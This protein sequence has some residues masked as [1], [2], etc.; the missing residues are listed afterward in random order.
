MT[1]TPRAYPIRAAARLTGVSIDTLRAWERRYQAVVPERGE[2]GRI[3]RDAHIARLRNLDALVRRGHPIGTIARL[4]DR[5]LTRLLEQQGRTGTSPSHAVDLH[6]VMIALDRLDLAGIDATLGRFALLLPPETFIA[7]VA[8]PLLRE[9]GTRW[10]SG[11]LTPA[12]EHLVSARVRTV[13]GSLLTTAPRSSRQPVVFATP[14]SERHELGLLAA[15]VLTAL[16][17]FQVIYLGPDLPVKEIAGAANKAGAAA[18]VI[19]AT[20]TDLRPHL[21]QLL[22]LAP[23]ADVFIGGATVDA[24]IAALERVHHVDDVRALVPQL[25][26][27]FA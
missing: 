10:A 4:D 14:S 13:L 15:A 1:N 20:V 11:A 25:Q 21:K 9:L 17:G 18:I 16:A 23:D 24:G 19:S 6:D 12:Q 2:R 3:Y 22:A 5:Q 8:L 26:E 7:R 27:R